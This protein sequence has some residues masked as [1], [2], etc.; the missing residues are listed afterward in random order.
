MTQIK[1]FNLSQMRRRLLSE[2]P[3]SL[4]SGYLAMA[5]GIIAQV[6][7]VPIYLTRLGAEGFGVLVL[8]L[9]MI[10]YT[11][12]GVGWLSGSL[13]RILGEAFGT[14]NNA[15]FVQ[16][17]DIGK[18]IYLAY[19][20]A[21]ALLGI[22]I[23][24][25]L[26]RSQVP[27]GAAIVA[28]FF[29]VATY[30]SAIE[31]LALIAAARLVAVNL[32]QFLQIIV[33][34]ISV[35]F[36]LLAGGGLLGVFACQLGSVLV[37]RILLPFCWQGTR[38][39]AKHIIG[40]PRPLLARLTGLMGGGYFLSGALFLSSQSDVLVI[41]WLGGAEAAARYVLLWKIAE[42][43]VTALWRISE[44][45]SPILV[46]L[47]AMNEHAAIKRQY[48]H[49]AT[50]LLVTA[51]PAGFAYALLGPWITAL[52]LGA[53]HAPKDSLGFVLAGTAIVWGGLARLPSILSY[54][55]ARF[56]VWNAIAF[57]EVMARLALTVALYPRFGY[58]SPLVALNIVHLCGIAA[59][60]QWAGWRLLARRA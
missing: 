34:A 12:I 14:R 46:R 29:L 33:Y 8:M 38:P 59:A 4:S 10:N 53:E 31:R 18:I 2:Y 25:F 21:A 54:S 56:R 3:L 20:A 55:L 40:T 32:L 51:I 58:L 50:L 43:G 1:M 48:W 60:Y 16:A 26:D 37:A 36:V 49:V 42:V 6:V 5:G 41:G 15:G 24:A 13:Q 27:L 39:I 57:A 52:W 23:V 45:W 7:L 44:S 11:T 22:T 47:D 19:G 28:G 17:V 35:V 30:E 9:A